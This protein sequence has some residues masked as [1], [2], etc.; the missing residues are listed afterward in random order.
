MLEYSDEYR[1]DNHNF[2]KEVEFDG[3]SCDEG[4]YVKEY[5]TVCG[6]GNEYYSKGHRYDEKGHIELS[7]YG[8]CGGWIDSAYCSICE[9]IV[10]VFMDDFSVY[11]TSFDD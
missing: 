11:G 1:R 10:E 4:Y 3:E 7:K 5:C 8:A 9:K 6:E 2:V